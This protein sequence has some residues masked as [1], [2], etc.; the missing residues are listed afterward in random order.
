[1]VKLFERI[2]MAIQVQENIG[3]V[4]QL[5]A[6]DYG[7]NAR[8]H[9]RIYMYSM[10]NHDLLLYS[11]IRGNHDDPTA[12]IGNNEVFVVSKSLTL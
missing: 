5:I 11:V 9:V 4:E 7:S 2:N 3:L 8:D 1:M 6:P 10:L 12:S